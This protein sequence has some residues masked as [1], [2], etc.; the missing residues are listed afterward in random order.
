[1]WVR[2][3]WKHIR[4]KTNSHIITWTWVFFSKI[5]RYKLINRC[6]IRFMHRWR[7]NENGISK[8][9]HESRS[10]ARNLQKLLFKKIFK[11]TFLFKHYFQND[12][13]RFIFGWYQ[14]M[15]TY[16]TYRALHTDDIVSEYIVVVP[17]LNVV[18]NVYIVF[19]TIG[20]SLS[21]WSI[22]AQN[23]YL[24]FMTNAFWWCILWH[25]RFPGID[26]FLY[27]YIYLE[28]PSNDFFPNKIKHKTY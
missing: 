10:D 8:E 25:V 1:M 27:I 14:S 6:A 21:N 13:F 15:M 22:L 16:Y 4:L 5:A 26:V 2:R 3:F 11:T 12:I 7:Q 28:E 24:Q 17:R 20:A 18:C 23:K 19:S 9:I